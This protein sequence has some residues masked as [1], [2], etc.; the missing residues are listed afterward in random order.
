M[1]MKKNITAFTAAL[2]LL[3]R[4]SLATHL[5][6]PRRQRRNAMLF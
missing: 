5:L 2:I 6:C 1:N 4:F 3:G